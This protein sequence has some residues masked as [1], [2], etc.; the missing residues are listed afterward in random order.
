MEMG[1]AGDP[2]SDDDG[3]EDVEEGELRNFCE[4]L[5]VKTA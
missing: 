2:G 3:D 4:G 5:A 1:A